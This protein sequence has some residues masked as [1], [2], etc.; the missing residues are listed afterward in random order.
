MPP[1]KQQ[2]QQ[3]KGGKDQKKQNGPKVAVDKTFG[4]KNKKGAAQQKQVKIIQ[5]QQG[6]SGKTPAQV[7]KER[8]RENE[9]K[10][11]AEAEKEKR[12]QASQLTI[13]QPKPAFGEDP[14]TIVCEYWRNG[15]CAKGT[16]CKYAHS[17]DA[18]RKVAKKDLYVDSR[19]AERE[20]KEADTMD[21]WDDAKLMSVVMSKHGNPKTTTDK[22]CKFFLQ[23]VENG[24]YGWFWECP[25]GG[26]KCM[27]RHRL[28][29]GFVLRSEQKERERLEK[30]NEISLEEFIEAQRLALVGKTLTPVTP[31]SFAKW[32][33]DRRDKKMA[34]EDMA[35]A[36]SAKTQAL[37]KASGLSGREMFELNPDMFADEVGVDEYDV[38]QYITENRDKDEEAELALEQR[39]FNAAQAAHQEDV[40]RKNH[41]DVEAAQHRLET[42]RIPDD[43]NHPSTTTDTD[44]HDDNT[45][46]TKAETVEPARQEVAA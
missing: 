24:K 28:P 44:T 43:S 5:Q 46:D 25:N 40:L 8:E 6:Q 36:K 13:V 2:Q 15:V 30:A 45:K 39:A 17:L 20:A 35:K 16:K 29:P 19:D 31:E 26:E 27:Y 4:L 32:K 11:R 37:S 21:N 12:K 7:A 9:K 42:L 3:Q 10:L 34:E 23:A 1:K 41:S 14:K 33:Q 22:V 38:S 18:G